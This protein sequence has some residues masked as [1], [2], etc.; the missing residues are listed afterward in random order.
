MN[1]IR[2]HGR[3]GQ[4][5]VTLAHLIAEAAYEQDMWAQAFP[6]FG[7]ERR[8]APVEAYVRIDDE[9]ITDRSQVHEPDYVVVQ[10]A[11]LIEFVDVSGGIDDA[12]VIMVNTADDPEHLDIAEDVSM[13]TVDATTIALEHL[14]KPIMNTALM[15]AFA[16]ATGIL[17]RESME[18]VIKSEFPGEIGEQNVAAT[19]AAFGEVQS[20]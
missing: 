10:D 20:V 1:E 8:G 19:T 2:I 5:S 3:G 18:T 4:G 7:V 6:A 13:V 16:S 14:G 9:Q 12:G 11:S 15:G 17:G